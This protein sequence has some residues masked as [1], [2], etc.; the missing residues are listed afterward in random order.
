MKRKQIGILMMV[1][2]LVTLGGRC[3]KEEPANDTTG[4]IATI[5]AVDTTPTGGTV[6]T[7]TIALAAPD[8][9]FVLDAAAAIL[10]EAAYSKTT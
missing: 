10:A 9:Q 2:L 5:T 6:T 4:S 8:Q 1:F 7:A 3:K